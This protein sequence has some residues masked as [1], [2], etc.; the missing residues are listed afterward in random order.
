[1]EIFNSIVLARCLMRILLMVLFGLSMNVTRKIA[2]GG[3]MTAL[4][5]IISYIEFL[6]PID[7]G[8]PGIKL[9]LANVV[10]LFVIY[11]MS[12]S[13]AILINIIRV[14]V[15]GSLFGNVTSTLFS[16]SGAVFS[17]AVM[18]AAYKIFKL[19]IVVVSVLGAVFHIIG[20]LVAG[21]FWY[22]VTVLM[23]YSVFLMI[24]AIVSGIIIG[25]LGSRLNMIYLK[26]R[27]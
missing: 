11:N 7:L 27:I 5:I 8:I 3:L 6:L 1:M 2:V 23:Y 13:E 12:P 4:A 9:G 22:P 24:A 21:L 16:L 25:I 10:I 20:Q 14:L 15:V 17:F 19:H 18:I 26:N